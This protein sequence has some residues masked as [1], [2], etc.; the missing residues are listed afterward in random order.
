M[1]RNFRKVAGGHEQ[2]KAVSDEQRNAI[3]RN[4]PPEGIRKQIFRFNQ[5]YIKLNC[6]RLT[7]RRSYDKMAA[8]LLGAPGS[9]VEFTYP[10]KKRGGARDPIE[11]L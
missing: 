8:M 7:H 5:K 3:S 4:R 10:P 6:V 1:D 9:N 2:Q 11:L